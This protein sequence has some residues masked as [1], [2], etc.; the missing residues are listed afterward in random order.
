MHYNEKI[1]IL[2]PVKDASGYLDLYFENLM[3]LNYP[4]ELISLGFIEGDSR[5]DS[6]AILESKLP[7]LRKTFRKAGLW[8][9]D[10]GFRIPEGL[11]R[12]TGSI[13]MARRSVLAKSRNH[14]LFRALEDEDRVL[15]LDVDVEAYPADIIQRLLDTRR[16]II[17]PN[18]VT[19]Y[20]GRSHDLNAWRDRGRQHLHDLRGEGDLVE[21]HSVGGAMLMVKADIHRD[22]LIFPTFPYGRKSRLIRRVHLF[23]VTRKEKI[24]GIPEAIRAWLSSTHQ[25]ELETEGLG[26]MAHDMGHKCW[27]MPNLEIKHPDGSTN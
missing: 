18:C 19:E 13:Q 1:L 4:R 15:W 24:L 5:D 17:Q 26:I 16:D 23:F 14:L 8:K 10:F 9:K 21:L 6:H 25:G 7:D 22:G 3:R 27:G 11:P 12:W 20:G 2:S